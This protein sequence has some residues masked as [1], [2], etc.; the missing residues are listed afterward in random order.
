MIALL[1]ATSEHL[2]RQ[3]K[4]ESTLVEKNI[5]ALG[6]LLQPALTLGLQ[7]LDAAQGR[8][9]PAPQAALAQAPDDDLQPGGGLA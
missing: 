3:L 5:D 6:Q 4:R 9:F 2:D 7:F 1:A 8:A